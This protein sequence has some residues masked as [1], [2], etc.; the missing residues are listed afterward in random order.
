MRTR[1]VGCVHSPPEYI[2]R[3]QISIMK[4][5]I[6]QV[7]YCTECCLGALAGEHVLNTMHHR[8]G[9]LPGSPCKTAGDHATPRPAENIA[10]CRPA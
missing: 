1:A 2:E 4:H 9:F 3:I 7:V 10:D 6:A 8:N 5:F